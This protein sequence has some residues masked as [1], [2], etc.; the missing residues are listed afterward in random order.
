MNFL[1]LY[2][3]Q[4]QSFT[5][6]RRSSTTSSF[7]HRV[8]LQGANALLGKFIH[9]DSGLF[10]A[11]LTGLEIVEFT[12]GYAKSKLLVSPP[13]SNSYNTLHG[14]AIS[15]IVDV[16]GTVALLTKDQ[17]KAG[18]TVE[19]NTSFCSAAKVGSMLEIEGKILKSG[20]TLGFTQVDIY[21]IDNS[22][23]TQQRKLVASGRHTKAF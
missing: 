15:T 22:T 4:L 18:V 14:G 1:K 21:S 3:K 11:C 23:E 9:P 5:Q 10:D 16:M 6:K 19:L 2:S 17:T 8:S 20:R 7:I 13:L 12:P